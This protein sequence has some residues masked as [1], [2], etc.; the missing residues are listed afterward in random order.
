MSKTEFAKRL[1]L[2][3][4][5]TQV[6]AKM[7]LDALDDALMEV[8]ALERHIRLIIG[9]IGGK[10]HP[11]PVDG[12]VRIGNPFFYPSRIAKRYK[13]FLSRYERNKVRKEFKKSMV[14]GQFH[15]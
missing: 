7:L 12:W 5:I 15:F 8:M 1:A 6:R 14:Y 9:V 3:C 10:R 13:F 11:V 4:G 2:K